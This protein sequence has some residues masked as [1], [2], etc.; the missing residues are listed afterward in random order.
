[1]MYETAFRR[2]VEEA[3][4][5]GTGAGE[6]VGARPFDALLLRAPQHT[7]N[8][9]SG[10]LRAPQ[11]GQNQVMDTMSV[12]LCGSVF[13]GTV[14]S[15]AESA[16]T[17]PNAS[18]GARVSSAKSSRPAGAVPGVPVRSSAEIG[19]LMAVGSASNNPVSAG[20]VPVMFPASSVKSGMLRAVVS[21]SNHPAAA[22]ASSCRAVPRPCSSSA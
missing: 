11:Q 8:F 14:G 6:N 16:G 4:G 13:S 5:T 18:E 9:A 22:G 10:A 2:E 17:I 21:A 15:Q 12:I 7:Q 19:M 3:A 20:A 1:M